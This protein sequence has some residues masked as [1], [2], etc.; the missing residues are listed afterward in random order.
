M[1]KIDKINKIWYNIKRFLISIRKLGGNMKT[2]NSYLTGYIKL[3]LVLFIIISLFNVNS[4]YSEKDIKYIKTSTEA[5]LPSVP[6][7]VKVTTP[8]VE[9]DTKVLKTYRGN[10]S[11]YGP[12]CYGCSGI[13]ASGNYID[14]NNIY[15]SDNEYGLVRIVAA[16]RSIPFGSIVR[17][18]I[19]NE[20]KIIAVV[21]DRGGAIGFNKRYMLDVLCT[22][23]KEANNTGRELNTKIEVL[24][25]GY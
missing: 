24:R 10:V 2:D 1:I 15:Y 23:E 13:T 6:R 18:N 22:S 14:D 4:T 9:K 25:Y 19:S 11:Y 20:D 21:L 8:K 5:I 12:D 7:V 3:F 16:D 17:I